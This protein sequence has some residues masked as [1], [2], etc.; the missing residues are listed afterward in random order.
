MC[1]VTRRA[2]PAQPSREFELGRLN[3]DDGNEAGPA[4]RA[5]AAIAAKTLRTDRWWF[6]PLITVVGLSAWLAYATVRVFMHKWYWVEEYH[7]L[8]PFYSPCITDR[9][10]P[11]AAHFGTLPARPGGSS[12]RRR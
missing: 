9:C 2:G 1:T 5:R 10:V 4:R 12:R 6:P 11:E 3:D 8:T 7:Y